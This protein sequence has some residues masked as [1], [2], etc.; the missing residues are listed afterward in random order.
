MTPEPDEL[1]PLIIP[2]TRSD[3]RRILGLTTIGGLAL[4]VLSP[5][6]LITISGKLAGLLAVLSIIAFAIA[7]VMQRGLESDPWRPK[8]QLLAD[9][10]VEPEPLVDLGLRDT[11][12]PINLPIGPGRAGFEAV[13]QLL[14]EHDEHFE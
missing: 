7:Y 12:E 13:E 6:A 4:L 14:E 10:A 5:V 1:N 11:P 3:R 2:P 9:T 8:Q